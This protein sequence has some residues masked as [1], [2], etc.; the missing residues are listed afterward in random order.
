MVDTQLSRLIEKWQEEKTSV[1]QR[2]KYDPEFK[3]NAVQLTEEPGRIVR[4]VGEYSKFCP[5]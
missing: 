1:Q 2:R 4:E 5:W 3:R